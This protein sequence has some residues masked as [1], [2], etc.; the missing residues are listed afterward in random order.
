[1]NQNAIRFGEQWTKSHSGEQNH[2]GQ[3]DSELFRDAEE[4]LR[5][6]LSLSTTT[7]TI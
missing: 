3:H 7:M 2:M 1:M 5:S 6:F 4:S